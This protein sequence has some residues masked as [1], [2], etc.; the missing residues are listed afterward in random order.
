MTQAER[1]TYYEV[2]DRAISRLDRY[3][4]IVPFSGYAKEMRPLI[5]SFLNPN[6]RAHRLTSYDSFGDADLSA[7][8]E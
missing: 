6:E 1:R 2:F 3:A 8:S 7:H 5:P 4:L